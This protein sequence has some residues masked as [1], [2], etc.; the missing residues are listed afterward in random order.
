MLFRSGFFGGIPEADSKLNSQLYYNLERRAK[1]LLLSSE[2]NKL[3][4]SAKKQKVDRIL[5]LAKKDTKDNIKRS[6]IIED[7][8]LEL[9]YSMDKKYNDRTIRQALKDL[10]LPE[11][12]SD[13]NFNQLRLLDSYMDSGDNYIKRTTY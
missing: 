6:F 7:R 13:L 9:M 11:E 1:M 2:F 12:L 5:Q 10:E 8:E 3:S 4:T